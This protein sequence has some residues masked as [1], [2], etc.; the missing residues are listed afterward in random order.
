MTSNQPSNPDD[1]PERV[2]AKAYF[3][4]P[5]KLQDEP[6]VGPEEWIISFLVTGI[7]GVIVLAIWNWEVWKK[8]ALIS[9]LVI[10]AWFVFVLLSG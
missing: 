2:A 10:A 7:P 5:R 3:Q 9:W 1:S 6:P 8:Y 4:Q